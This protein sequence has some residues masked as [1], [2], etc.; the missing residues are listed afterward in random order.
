M[1]ERSSIEHHHSEKSY[2]WHEYKSLRSWYFVKISVTHCTTFA[3]ILVSCLASCIVFI[4]MYLSWFCSTVFYISATSCSSTQHCSW[5][6]MFPFSQTLELST[7]CLSLS[8]LNRFPW[9]L[10][11]SLIIMST[12]DSSTVTTV[13]KYFTTSV[14]NISSAPS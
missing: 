8:L 1:S 3:F 4:Y 14:I 7:E 9:L 11:S 13:Y 6:T 5:T 2:I 12:L 10:I